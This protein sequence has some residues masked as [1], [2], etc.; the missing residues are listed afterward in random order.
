MYQRQLHSHSVYYFPFEC[1]SKGDS[2]SIYG[3]GDCG[4]Q[5]VYQLNETKYC[6]VKDIIDVNAKAMRGQCKYNIISL[7]DY[8]YENHEKIVIAIEN[9]KVSQEVADKLCKYGVPHDAIIWKIHVQHSFG[10][11][12]YSCYSAIHKHVSTAE[13][14]YNKTDAKFRYLHD[15]KE[16]LQRFSLEDE[17]VRVGKDND[18]GYLMCSGIKREATGIA[19]SFGIANDV[20]WDLDMTSYEQRGIG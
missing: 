3:Y 6:Q 19:Y 20:S 8:H 14:L 18:G 4:K 2:V 1:I 10:P 17:L 12:Y 5:Y 11:E 7:S 9:P 16:L 15:I 13:L